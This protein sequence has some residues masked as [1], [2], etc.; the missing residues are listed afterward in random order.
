[1]GYYSDMNGEITAPSKKTLEKIVK[2]AKDLFDNIERSDLTILVYGTGKYYDDWMVPFY[3]LC[4]SYGCI[5]NFRRKGEDFEDLEET[6]IKPRIIERR[7]AFFPKPGEGEITNVP[8]AD[9]KPQKSRSRKSAFSGLCSEK[10]TTENPKVPSQK[11]PL[12]SR[13]TFPLLQ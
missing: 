13:Q 6:D 9:Q 1:M 11:Q 10:H 3:K 12:A 7:F 4:A 8:L 5:A 2:A